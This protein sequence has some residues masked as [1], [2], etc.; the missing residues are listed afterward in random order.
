MQAHQL[1]K[2]TMHQR[3]MSS[4]M[5]ILGVILG[6]VLSIL[7]S[8][9]SRVYSK[10]IEKVLSKKAKESSVRK[11]IVITEDDNEARDEIFV[12]NANEG[13]STPMSDVI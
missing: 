12:R 10:E 6:V 3:P 2:T 7:V 1:K 13:R 8:I 11:S 9:N 4:I 5:F